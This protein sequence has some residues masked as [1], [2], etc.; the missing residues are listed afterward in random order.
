MKQINLVKLPKKTL[1]ELAKMYSR[2][3][4]SLDANWFGLV[5]EE[6]GLE[7]AARLDLKSWEKQSV[8]E[9]ERIK[10]V[11]QLDKGGL[12]SVLTV[13][14]FMSWQLTSPLFELE[15]ETPERVVLYYPRCAV[16][17]SRNKKGKP[18][19]PCKTMKTTLLTNIARVAEPRAVV[20]CLSCPPD[21]PQKGY[22]C[23]WELTLR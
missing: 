22:R 4:Q 6:F 9:A 16:H 14:S 7:T 17:E 1:I 19:F 20:R 21:P 11:L 15:I 12:S 18:V 13:L 5:E 23:K 8:L 3:W 10:K 2:N